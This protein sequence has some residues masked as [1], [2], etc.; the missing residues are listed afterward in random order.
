MRLLREVGFVPS[1]VNDKWGREIFI[2]KR[3]S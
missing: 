2:A 1:I 3:P